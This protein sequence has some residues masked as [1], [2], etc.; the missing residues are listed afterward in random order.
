M[1]SMIFLNC[2]IRWGHYT[3]TRRASQILKGA[4]GR[5]EFAVFCWKIPGTYSLNLIQFTHYELMGRFCKKGNFIM[6]FDLSF[7]RM[8][9]FL[10]GLSYRSQIGPE[11]KIFW[12]SYWR[13]REK[14]IFSKSYHARHQCY[15][16]FPEDFFAELTFSS[17]N[18]FKTQNKYVCWVFT[19]IYFKITLTW[20]QSGICSSSCLEMRAN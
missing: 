5:W 14:E 6:L 17:P 16:F 10:N 8:L 3:K 1:Y 18:P 4:P 20:G 7:F 12:C 13:K 2:N 11:W 9:F 15:C 19:K